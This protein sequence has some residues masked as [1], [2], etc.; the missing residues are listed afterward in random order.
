VLVERDPGLGPSPTGGAAGSAVYRSLGDQRASIQVEASAPSLVLVR[1]VFDPNWHATV[2]G[3]PAS[4]LV[5]DELMQA[6]PVAAG[7][8]TIVLRYDD[9]SIGYGLL[10]SALGVAALAIAALLLGRLKRGA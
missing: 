3:R 9:P 2:D 10:G 4:V 7:R 1:N 6:V 5:A 8:H